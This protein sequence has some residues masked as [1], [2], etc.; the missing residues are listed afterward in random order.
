MP[1]YTFKR[2]FSHLS[3][4][5]LL[6]R[7]TWTIFAIDKLQLLLIEML[8]MRHYSELPAS[9]RSFFFTLSPVPEPNRLTCRTNAT[10][11]SV[12][13]SRGRRERVITADARLSKHVTFSDRSGR[14]GADEL[15]QWPERVS[16]PFRPSRG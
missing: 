12:P 2:F 15:P 4:F 10:Y 5:C 6:M 11:Q 7:T 16:G 3:S 1:L 8:F 9:K 14:Y 13:S